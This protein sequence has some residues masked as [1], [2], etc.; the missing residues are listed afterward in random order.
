[1]RYCIYQRKCTSF[2]LFCNGCNCRASG[3]ECMQCLMQTLCWDRYRSIPQLFGCAPA[4]SHWRVF[5]PSLTLAV[6]FCFQSSCTSHSPPFP[7]E[8]IDLLE[9]VLAADP[10]RR[11]SARVALSS[12]FFHHCPSSRDMKPLGQ[13]NSL[14]IY[15]IPLLV[16]V[17]RCGKR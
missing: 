10:S 8:V 17:V 12:R 16:F 6:Q 11:A 4:N 9:R 3:P 2:F 5:I 1:M 15:L 14:P 7:A 13:P